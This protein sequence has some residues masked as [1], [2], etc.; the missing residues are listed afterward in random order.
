MRKL[1]LPLL[2]VLTGCGSDSSSSTNPE[3][4]TQDN[5]EQEAPVI[6]PI[7]E[8]FNLGPVPSNFSSWDEVDAI[9]PETGSLM[10]FDGQDPDLA[11]CSIY[12]IGQTTDQQG[13][14]QLILRSSFSHNGDGH[15]FFVTTIPSDFERV[16][17]KEVRLIGR[18]ATDPGE[19]S[20]SFK[21]DAALSVENI[22]NVIIKWWHKDHFD[23]NVCN[24]LAL[25]DVEESTLQLAPGLESLDEID[26]VD[27]SESNLVTWK[28]I[29]PVKEAFG[30]PDTSCYVYLMAVNTDPAL[31]LPLYYLRSSFNH[32]GASH[33]AYA[34]NLNE[35]VEEKDYLEVPANSE[36][37]DGFFRYNLDELGSLD[38]MTQVTI[39]WLHVDHYHNDRCTDLEKVN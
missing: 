12:V 19:I 18:N 26:S 3:N 13:R 36:G 11:S 33:K 20:V 5:Q 14:T 25:R 17:G 7:P 10:I 28:G 35:V 24:S 27:A 29:D 16:D 22:A 30:E 2:L 31:D 37:D 1:I 32:G 38:S 15:P 23:V 8:D 34:V 39:R 6:V 4:G 9:D 21:V